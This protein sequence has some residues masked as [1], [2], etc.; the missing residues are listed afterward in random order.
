LT[1]FLPSLY[2]NMW[3]RSR[4]LCSCPNCILE[5]LREQ[6]CVLRINVRR[7][8]EHTDARHRE[9]QR[10]NQGIQEELESLQTQLHQ[11]ETHHS[12]ELV[13]ALRGIN[14]NTRQ[15][16]VVTQQL[17]N[18]QQPENSVGSIESRI[19]ST[20]HSTSNNEHY[21]APSASRHVDLHHAEANPTTRQAEQ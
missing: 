8:E 2:T 10:E 16:G 11:Q 1:Y 6:F 3:R 18:P 20:F 4:A 12:Q 14:K 13:I 5:E 9:F 17:E 19:P 7:V 15:L 21:S